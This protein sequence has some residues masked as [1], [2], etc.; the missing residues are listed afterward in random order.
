[1]KVRYKCMSIKTAVLGACL[2]IFNSA[3]SQSEDLIIKLDKAEDYGYLQFDNP[4]GSVNV[5]GYEGS[6]IIVSGT[7]RYKEKEIGEEGSYRK[8]A[9]PRFSLSAEEKD[10][11][12]FLIC[13]SYGNIIDFDIKVPVNMSVRL[14]CLDNGD[15]SIYRIKGEIEI[16]NKYGNIFAGNISGSSVINTTYGNI[17]VVFEQLNTDKPSMFSSFDGDIELVFPEGSKASLKIRSPRG[18]ILSRVNLETY[19]RKTQLQSGQD[20]NRYTLEDWTRAT[21]NGGGVEIIVSSYSG[22]IILKNKKD[23]TFLPGA[24]SY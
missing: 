15:V 7:P 9:Q 4:T 12:V 22:D 21:L 13:E 23:V 10:N 19:E 14:K 3:Y 17:R 5:D 16:E 2:L 11:N 6:M 20:I 8:I 1:M 24:G 18:N